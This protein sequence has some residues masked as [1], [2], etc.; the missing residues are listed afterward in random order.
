MI[1]EPGNLLGMRDELPKKAE[2]STIGSVM[3][4]QT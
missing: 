1:C 3:G 4:K 2:H